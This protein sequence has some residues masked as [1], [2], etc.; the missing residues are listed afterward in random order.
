M[1]ERMIELIIRAAYYRGINNAEHT[2]RTAGDDE[3]A[4]GDLKCKAMRYLHAEMDLKSA[5]TMIEMEATH[6]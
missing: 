1:N 5:M 3:S 4:I 2:N 6:D